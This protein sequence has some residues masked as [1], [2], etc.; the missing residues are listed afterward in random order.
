[1]DL[2][3]QENISQLSNQE[4]FQQHDYICYLRGDGWQKNAT[5]CFCIPLFISLYFPYVYY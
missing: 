2:C 1:M 3:H 4:L 5:L